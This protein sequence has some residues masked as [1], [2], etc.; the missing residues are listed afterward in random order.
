MLACNIKSSYSCW[1]KIIIYGIHEAK[2]AQ[3]ISYWKQFVYR[4]YIF[5]YLHKIT[6]STL[7]YIFKNLL[8]K[9]TYSF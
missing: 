7:R 1:I 6:K 8:A 4:C 2:C 3:V 9:D 5:M